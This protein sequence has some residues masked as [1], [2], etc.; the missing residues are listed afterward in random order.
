MRN[1]RPSRSRTRNHHNSAVIFTPWSRTRVSAPGGPA[2]CHTAVVPRPGSSTVLIEALEG[3]IGVRR[4]T[5]SSCA[6]SISSAGSAGR[7]VGQT[8][9]LQAS[10]PQGY[11]LCCP[12]RLILFLSGGRAARERYHETIG[13]DHHA[14]GVTEPRTCRGAGGG[15]L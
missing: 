9:V 13:I 2:H 5:F 12:N 4:T 15:C 11:G 3:P 6:E 7:C 8:A 10:S 14:A 1:R